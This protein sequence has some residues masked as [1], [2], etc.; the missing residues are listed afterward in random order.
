MS[1]RIVAAGLDEYE[2]ALDLR[3]EMSRD[4]HESA[5]WDESSPGWRERFR[6]FFTERQAL[7][8]AQLFLAYDGAAAIGMCITYIGEH[9]RT[10][11]LGRTYAMLHGVFVKP[12][13]R[14]R[15]IARALTEAAIG[16]ARERQCYSVRLHSSEMAR[17]LY[18]SFGFEPT[19][20]LELR[21]R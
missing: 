16:W 13:Y 1:V 3:A 18:L 12:V 14:Q 6:E 8:R 17:P 10:A 15:G 11:V 9:Y 4:S 2:A 20:E 7:D 19:S 5:P 21:L